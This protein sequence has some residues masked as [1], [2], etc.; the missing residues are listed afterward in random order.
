MESARG[1]L[2]KINEAGFMAYL[3]GGSV[4][5]HLMGKKP[6]DFDIATNALP[7]DIKAIFPDTR[8]T[9][10]KH[11][12][13]TAI[14]DE[15]KYEITTFRADGEYIDGRRPGSVNFINDLNTDLSRRD[16]TINAI[17]L[18]A[19]GNMID[20]FEGKKHIDEKKIQTVGDPD[21]RF[22]EDSLRMIRAVRFS[23]QL[24]FEIEPVT[25]KAIKNNRKKIRNVS[26]E[27]IT[28]EIIKIVN[29][30]HVEK[31]A[32]L[33]STG[34]MHEI[35]RSSREFDPLLLKRIPPRYNYRL[36]AFIN[37]SSTDLNDLSLSS[38]NIEAYR[39]HFIS[40]E[41]N[42]IFLKKLLQKYTPETIIRLL[43]FRSYYE[44]SDY[45]LRALEQIQDILKYN[46]PYDIRHLSVNGDDLKESGINEGA[47]IGNILSDLLDIVMIH[48][49]KN[50][51]D[52]LLDLAKDM[53]A[54]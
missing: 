50:K 11:G 37:M 25:L 53:T 5:D 41:N 19:E 9:G 43:F 22:D 31:T 12:T 6:Y 35:S 45:Y 17:A 36:Y 47:V 27:R 1:I 42:R 15:V 23:C 44:D 24:G 49:E 54:E 7:E 3:V 51:R 10:I 20:P 40:I 16:F 18:D 21:S 30:R 13:V 34:L 8:D 14:V 26:R 32:Y 29:S 39:I 4:R 48:P 46:E 38:A 28:D 2:K 52:V 33:F